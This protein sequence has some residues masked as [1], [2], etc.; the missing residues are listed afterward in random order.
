ME[1]LLKRLLLLHQFLIR[2]SII[3]LSSDRKTKKDSQEKLQK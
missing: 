2:G 1:L 3:V